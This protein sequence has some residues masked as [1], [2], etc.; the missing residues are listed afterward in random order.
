MCTGQFCHFGAACKADAAVFAYGAFIMAVIN[1]S[2]VAFL[3]FP[4]M[5]N[6]AMSS[7][8]SSTYRSSINF[9]EPDGNSLVCRTLS[10]A[11]FQKTREKAKGNMT[12][13]CKIGIVKSKLKQAH[14]L[15]LNDQ[16]ML[17]F[18]SCLASR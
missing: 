13:V 3:S 15:T 7:R 18:P 14:N 11:L 6:T 9:S 16:K 12:P 17:T 2:V 5:C 10:G 8:Y 1:F 4:S